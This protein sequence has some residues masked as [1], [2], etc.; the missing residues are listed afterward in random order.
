M[1]LVVPER[2]LGRVSFGDMPSVTQIS[3]AHVGLVIMSA[4]LDLGG[5]VIW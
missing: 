3:A 2:Q 1:H 5:G 4:R